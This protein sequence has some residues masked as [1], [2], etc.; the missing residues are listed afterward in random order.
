MSYSS[1]VMKS[2]FPRAPLGNGLGRYVC[3]LQ[4]ITLKFCKTHGGSQ[5]MREF[6]ETDL[7][8]FARSN[9]GVVVYLKPRRF[10]T[11]CLW[12]EY[13][14][15]GEEY[16]GC[17]NLSKEEISQWLNWMKTKS[18]YQDMRYL[19]YS[20]S[21]HPSVQGVWSP[22]THRDPALN[23][24]TF[25][26]DTLTIAERQSPSATEILMEMYKKQQ[27]TEPDLSKSTQSN[28]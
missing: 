13:L 10:R 12:A 7:I 11:P 25:P 17:N 6:I 14:N 27:Q 18:G 8:D 23:L 3:Q 19:S 16:I 1:L 9:P 20:H 4:R 15:G 28:E 5:G 24:A 2:M 21:D 22:F 26:L